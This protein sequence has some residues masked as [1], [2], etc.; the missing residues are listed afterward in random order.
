[1]S[2]AVDDPYWAQWMD[3]NYRRED[4]WR[5]PSAMAWDHKHNGILG[6]VLDFSRSEKTT[7]E[8]QMKL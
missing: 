1:V 3:K 2:M 5:A 7:K 8:Q 4:N 6:E